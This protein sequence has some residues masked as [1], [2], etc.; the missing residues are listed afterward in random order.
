MKIGASF[1]LRQKGI[2][3]L[4]EAEV[5]R[6]AGGKGLM[7]RADKTKLKHSLFLSFEAP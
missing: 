6:Q 7:F 3:D 2:A 1:F 5:D 4:H